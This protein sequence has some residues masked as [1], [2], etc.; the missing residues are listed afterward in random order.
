M[1]ISKYIL[2]VFALAVLGACNDE[3]GKDTEFGLT[4][5]TAENV[6]V[7]D[8][9]TVEVKA[10]TPLTF[11]F[12]GNPD[13]LAFFS[14]EPGKKYAYAKRDLV[15]PEDIVSSRL[16]FSV[17]AQY[18]NGE[19]TA[20]VLSMYIA[21][22]FPGMVKN[23]FRADSAL[24]E[25]FKW[26]DLLDQSELPQA[27]GNAKSAPTFDIDMKPY[28]GKRVTIA[29]R[30]KAL[31]NTAAQPRMNFVDMKIVNKMKDGTT[32]ELN[33]GN[34]GFTPLNMMHRHDL[35]DQRNMKSNR[36]YGSVTNNMS[37]IWNLVG[38]NTGNFF[39]HSSGAGADLKYSWML[40]DMITVNAASP[41]MGE[42]LKNISHSLDTYTYTYRT[43][44]EYTATFIASKANYKTSS[45]V[46]KEMK[47]K[48]V[49]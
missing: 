39:I 14:G 46:V 19:N 20:G 41:D 44:G 23:D 12:D 33:A 43:P 29:I 16:T 27:P 21:D 3:M 15:D 13:N 9:N 25:S 17:W 4:T 5:Q 28:L 48:V 30:Y 2:P 47:I 10:G 8:G 34:F 49:Q 32:S 35:K 42:S 11:V 22:N 36:A 24:V 7:I 40:S 6:K 45:S 38:A 37:G 26:N 1:K 31:K 18:G